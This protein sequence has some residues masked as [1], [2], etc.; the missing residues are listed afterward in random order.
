MMDNK[1]PIPISMFK[2]RVDFCG[3]LDEDD[4]NDTIELFVD[5]DPSHE[6]FISS[7]NGN[8]ILFVQTCGYEFIFTADGEEPAPKQPKCNNGLEP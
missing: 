4:E 1:K 7:V 5:S 3:L 8:K 6:F 2:E